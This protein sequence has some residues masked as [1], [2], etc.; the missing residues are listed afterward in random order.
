MGIQTTQGSG[1]ER[2]RWRRVNLP[3][4][5][6][7]FHRVSDGAAG[8]STV[9]DISEMGLGLM[10]RQSVEIGTMIRFDFVLPKK[11]GA[12][13]YGIG[14]VMWTSTSTDV[15][16]DPVTHFGIEFT[17][18]NDEGHK[19]IKIIINHISKTQH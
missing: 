1:A 12:R 16:G 9:C 17:D 8:I 7:V 5:S 6:L 3:D 14:K 13:V 11:K 15:F 18:I 2:R 10:T 4:S 19:V